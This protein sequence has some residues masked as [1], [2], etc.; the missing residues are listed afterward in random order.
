ML[1]MRLLR[2]MLPH[3]LLRKLDLMRCRLMRSAVLLWSLARSILP[4]PISTLTSRPLCSSPRRLRIHVR[5]TQLS[6]LCHQPLV[7]AV[8]IIPP[9][10]NLRNHVVAQLVHFDRPFLLGVAFHTIRV[11]L[12]KGLQQRREPP[13]GFRRPDRVST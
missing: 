11:Y 4:P 2:V 5:H 7:L 9:N 3:P 1:D 13:V 8:R 10:L 6:H 12:E